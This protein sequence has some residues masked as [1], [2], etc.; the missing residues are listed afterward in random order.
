M[1]V[2][3][4]VA[5][6]ALGACA[7]QQSETFVP[8]TRSA[9]ELR[10]MQSRAINGSPDIVARGVIAT[11]HDLGYRLTRVDPGSGTISATKS[12]R[13]RLA[14]VV[15]TQGDERS[16]VRANAVILMPPASAH[17]VD[18]PDF[19]RNNFFAPLAA[20]MGRNMEAVPASQPVPDAA[21]PEPESRTPQRQP[22]EE[23]A[24]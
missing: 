12:D 17:E 20:T 5:M 19:Y 3:L 13:L 21:R 6:C 14:A 16:V 24:R 7:Q 15:R 23:A 11:L 22:A 9:V 1:K 2:A 18:S 10:A 4:L 8:S